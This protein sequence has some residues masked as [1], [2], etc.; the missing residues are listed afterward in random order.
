MSI[1]YS[2]IILKVLKRKEIKNYTLFEYKGKPIRIWM[3]LHLKI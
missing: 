3:T 1:L 2:I